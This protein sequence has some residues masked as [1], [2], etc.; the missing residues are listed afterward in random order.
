MRLFIAVDPGARF[1]AGLSTRLDAW[2]VRLP[3]AWVRAANLHVTLRFLGELPEPALPALASALRGAVAGHGPFTLQPGGVGA[4][5]D[6]RAPRVL[7][8]QMDSPG[9]ELARLATAVRTA[10]DPLL[11]PDR[12]DDR[13]LR[14]HLTLARV[15][16]PLTP[17]QARELA[18]IDP[19]AW[20]PLTVDEVG[21]MR[22]VTGP[23]GPVYT[24]LLAVALTGGG[25]IA[26]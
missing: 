13:P 14:A 8:L 2:R 4:F 20:V 3:L 22:S 24:R 11:P 19:G 10:V 25:S 7:F 12:C 17:A 26:G 5:P 15:K 9:G 18:A 23:A 21:L 16:Q 1:R 6:L